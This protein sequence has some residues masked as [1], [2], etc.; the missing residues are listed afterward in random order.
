MARKN[1]KSKAEKPIE[2][3]SD[4]EDLEKDE[5]EL[6]LEK[7]VFGDL[8]GFETGL[9]A[10]DLDNFGDDEGDNDEDG[11][12]SDREIEGSDADNDFGAVQDDNLFFVDD[13]AAAAGMDISD[14]EDISGSD[15]DDSDNESDFTDPD[16]VLDV[17]GGTAAWIDSDDEKLQVSLKSSDKLKKLRKSLADNVVD[18]KEYTR[19]LRSRFEKMYPV[20]KWARQEEPKS[21]GKS[22]SNSSDEEDNDIEMD[23]SEEPRA[24]TA[25]PLAKLLTTQ[26]TYIS[27]SIPRL[28]PPSVLDITRLKDANSSLVSKSG[29]Q[30][31]DFHPTHP[32]LLSGGYDRTLRMYHID[33]KSNP[34]ATSLHVRSSPFQ[35]A[36]FHKDGTKV[37][38][39]GRRRNLYIW[40]IETGKVDTITRMYGHEDSQ[41]SMEKF[42]LSPDGQYIGLIGSGGW[43]NILS[44]ASGQWV[45]GAKV[46]GVI[47]DIAWHKTGN[48]SN[49]SIVNTGGDIW[50]W[51]SRARKFSDKWK[52]EGGLGVTTMSIGGKNDRWC[53]VGSASGIVNVYDRKNP[54][55]GMKLSEAEAPIYKPKAVLD[56]LVT[57]ISS[58]QFSPDGQMLAMGSRA[59]KDSF[60][61]AHVP[62]FTVFKN[63]P[64]SG[65]PLGRVTSVAFTPGTEMICAGNDAGKA[66]LW[67]FNHYS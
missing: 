16:S 22:D 17:H 45:T 30:T 8:D 61:I 11:E 35:T 23:D 32:L 10:L 7:I 62:S 29:V 40:D 1:N 34:V 27:K 19:R 26:S 2:P 63:W 6:E 37:F 9:K 54:V 24:L 46:E 15:V 44:T 21:K 14:D 47:A 50:E 41:K 48:F 5:E 42:R 31:L 57:S 28:L 58:L 38:A 36:L 65:T 18:G 49:L 43:V 53:A 4:V 59:K 55:V 60:R 3:Q 39:G 33:G 52:D 13:S 67:K 51:D 66:R 64:T 20:P 25:D 56:Q 12:L